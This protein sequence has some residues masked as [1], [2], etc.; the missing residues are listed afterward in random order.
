MAVRAARGAVQIKKNSREAIFEATRRLLKEM[1]RANQVKPE[2]MI[3]I[4]LTMTPDLNADFPAY[5]AREIGW[6]DVPLLCASEISVT[7]AMKKVI[8]AL[9]HLNTSKKQK[10]IKHCY[11]GQTAKLRPDLK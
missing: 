7:K 11:L 9:M 10:A 6:T 4:F 5:A 8:R 1:Q 2:D 3:S